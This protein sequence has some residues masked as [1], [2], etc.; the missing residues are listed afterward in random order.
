MNKRKNDDES[1]I[2]IAGK[3]LEQAKNQ[4]RISAVVSSS[5]RSLASFGQ[6]SFPLL[7]KGENALTFFTLR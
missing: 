3:W 4:E 1:V 6:D 2:F 5:K 7:L